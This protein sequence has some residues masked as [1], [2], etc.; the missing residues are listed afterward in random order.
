MSLNEWISNAKEHTQCTLYD[1]Q[2]GRAFLSVSSHL[3]S[4]SPKQWEGVA[5]AASEVHCATWP[6]PF[7]PAFTMDL[8]IWANVN[9]YF[10]EHFLSPFPHMG[11]QRLQGYFLFVDS[12]LL[13]NILLFTLFCMPF[14]FKKC[15]FVF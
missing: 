4:S 11:E 6:F 12:V 5:A 2:Q 3:G 9:W 10:W 8:T 14:L 7:L 1:T 13:I 15:N